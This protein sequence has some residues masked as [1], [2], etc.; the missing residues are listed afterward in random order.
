MESY[1]PRRGA[2]VG[3]GRGIQHSQV[4]KCQAGLLTAVFSEKTQLHK[5]KAAVPA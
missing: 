5:G 4:S 3:T 2:A 1:G